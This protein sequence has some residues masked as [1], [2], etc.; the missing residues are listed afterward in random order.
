MNSQAHNQQKELVM[1][2]KGR[3]H[4]NGKPPMNMPLPPQGVE[5]QFITGRFMGGKS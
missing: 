1:E 3:E 4:R 5:W 2:G